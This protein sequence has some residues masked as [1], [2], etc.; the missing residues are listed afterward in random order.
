MLFITGLFIGLSIG[1][2]IGVL[3]MSMLQINRLKDKEVEQHAR[4]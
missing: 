3:F 4:D 1:A 2:F